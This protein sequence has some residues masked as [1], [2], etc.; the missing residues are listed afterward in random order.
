MGADWRE[1]VQKRKEAERRRIAEEEAAANVA[2]QAFLVAERGKE[3]EEEG[4]LLVLARRK[5][6]ASDQARQDA[7]AQEAAAHEEGVRTW[8]DDEWLPRLET[9]RQQ[10]RTDRLA[11]EQRKEE[12]RQML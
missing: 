1:Q 2:L 8:L 11:E 6:A 7:R 9:H 5:W 12:L 10:L 4:T 3:R